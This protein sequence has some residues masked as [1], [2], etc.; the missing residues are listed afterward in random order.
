MEHTLY[1]NTLK[2]ALRSRGIT[3]ADLAKSLKMTES[4][5]KKMLN[6]KDISFQ[7]I[8]KICKVI[9]V[10]PSQIFSISERSS[11]PTYHLSEKQ[12]DA[13][14]K[15]RRLL[16]V[17]WLLTIERKSVEDM[18]LQLKAPV[19]DIRIRLQKLVSLDLVNQK[20]S[21]FFPKHHRKF[22]WPDNSKLARILNQEWSQQTLKKALNLKEGTLG[23]HRFA[24]LKLSNESYSQL[25]NK[26]AEIF[27]EIAQ[28]SE[29]EELTNT[30]KDL[31][32][33]TVML[34]TAP[35]GA[36]EGH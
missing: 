5:V 31:L 21:E 20:K 6:A 34:A 29:R 33:F 30:N 7:R 15:D 17:Y 4:G 26:F 3:Y 28:I 2:K 23:M 18:G 19:Q 16:A 36:F 1:L 12:Q 27:N 35:G 25:L 9:D 10:L 14:V 11:V 24:A 22:R 13:L 8:L 32:D